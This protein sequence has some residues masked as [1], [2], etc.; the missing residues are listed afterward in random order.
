M[1]A[2]TIL[3]RYIRNQVSPHYTQ[4]TLLRARVN[5]KITLFVT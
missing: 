4:L 5:L 3:A 1:Y 2:Y